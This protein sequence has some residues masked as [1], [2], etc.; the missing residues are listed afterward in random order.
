MSKPTIKVLARVHPY[1]EAEGERPRLLEEKGQVARTLLH[2]AKA[3]EK[4]FTSLEISSWALRLSHYV[5]VLRNDGVTIDME[6]E[7]HEGPSGDGWQGRYYLRN[8][9]EILA[10]RNAGKAGGRADA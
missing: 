2:A 5:F 8:R 10:I 6:R 1:P 9:V 7:D 4:G 3:G